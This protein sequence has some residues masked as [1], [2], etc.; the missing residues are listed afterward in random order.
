VFVAYVLQRIDGIAVER[1]LDGDVR[2]GCRGRRAVPVL[3]AGRE[4]DHVAEGVARC[5]SRSTALIRATRSRALTCVL[6]TIFSM[7]TFHKS[8]ASEASDPGD[9]MSERRAII[10]ECPGD[11]VG[12]RT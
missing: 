11:F 6:L 1:F 4:K 12:I 5:E 2:H 10:S 9:I 3:F 8:P 7:A